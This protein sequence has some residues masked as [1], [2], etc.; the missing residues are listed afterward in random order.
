[1]IFLFM[2][3]VYS[4]SRPNFLHQEYFFYLY[5]FYFTFFLKKSTVIRSLLTHLEIVARFIY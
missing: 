3:A 5:L 1:M 4:H 2:P